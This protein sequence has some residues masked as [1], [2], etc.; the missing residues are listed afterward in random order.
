M[1]ANS[2][3]N[4]MLSKLNSGTYALGKLLTASGDDS[5][6]TNKRYSGPNTH[7]HSKNTAVK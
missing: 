2:M 7:T 4:S 3:K 6:F 1:P 5:V